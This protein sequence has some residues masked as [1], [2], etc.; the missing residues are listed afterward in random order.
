[1]GDMVEQSE[2]RRLAAILVADMFEYSRLM[3]TDERG[4]IARQK[5]HRAELIEP[6]ITEHHGRIVKT[7]G[8]G[9]LVEFVSVV[10]AVECAVAIQRAMLEREAEFPNDRR[11]RYRVGINLGDIVVEGDDIFGDGVNIA[12]RLEEMAEPGGLLISGTAYDHLKQKVNAGYEN[13]GEVRVKN[14]EAPVRVYRVMLG[15]EVVGRVIGEKQPGSTPRPFGR[16]AAAV[17][18]ALFVAGGALWWIKPWAPEFEPASVERM[19]YPLP[20]KP[21]IAVLP[22]DTFSKESKQNYIADGMTESLIA[23]LSKMPELFV[24]A[25]NSTST[26]KGKPV[27]VQKVAEDLGVRYVLEGSVQKTDD[28]LRITVQLIDAIS[29]N[30]LWSERYDRQ[31]KDL[32]ELQDDVI[33]KVLVE[34]QVKLTEGDNAR[35]ASRKTANLDAWLLR[36]QALAEGFKFTREGFV[37]SRELYQAAHEADPKWSRP[38]AGIAWTHEWDARRGWSASKEES[39]QTGIEL[40]RKAIDLDPMDPLGYQIL[41]NLYFIRGDYSEAI[42]LK[43]K[44]LELAPNSF[45]AMVGLAS[46]L[47]RGGEEQRALVLFT[48]AKRVSPIPIWWLLSGEGTALHMAGQNERAVEILKQAIGLKPNRADLHTRMA[49]VLAS[50]GRIDEAREEIKATLKLSPELTISRV[51]FLSEFQ[52]PKTADW[53]SDLLRKAGLPD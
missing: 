26:Y 30:H 16:T 15:P 45:P 10:D 1:M 24:I 19:A 50:L 39:V 13:L 25:R 31:L 2:Q 51:Y 9:M 28:R 40:A 20:D 53:Y 17:V 48:R 34:L 38:L 22:F 46:L 36:V 33:N 37:R 7:T 43:E 5:A 47:Y 21:S 35:V 8:D 11:I 41:G 12:A 4:T 6:K 42:A 44:A 18:V 23:S 49:A 52:N 27:K 29:G 3:E 32:F 14:I